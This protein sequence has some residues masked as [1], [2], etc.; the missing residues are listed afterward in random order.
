GGKGSGV[1]I[2]GAAKCPGWGTPPAG[3][4]GRR[5]AARVG[6]SPPVRSGRPRRPGGAGRAGPGGGGGGAPPTP[7]PPPPH[8]GRRGRRGAPLGRGATGAT[9]AVGKW[10]PRLADS[11]EP[12]VT[13]ATA[14]ETGAAV[15]GAWTGS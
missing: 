2:V 13:E 15:G 12:T 11:P 7:P 3:A 10:I 8:P 9:E 4:R 5:V 14:H 6:T 1:K